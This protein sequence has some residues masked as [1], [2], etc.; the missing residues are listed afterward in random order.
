MIVL[1]IS[2]ISGSARPK[3]GTKSLS[4]LGYESL[5]SIIISASIPVADVPWEHV[6]RSG[7]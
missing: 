7:S 3:K 1:K 4:L 5:R 6:Y 2:L